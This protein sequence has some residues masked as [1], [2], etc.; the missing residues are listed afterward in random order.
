MIHSIADSIKTKIVKAI[1]DGLDEAQNVYSTGSMRIRNSIHFYKM[2]AIAN[3]VI[4]CLEDEDDIKILQ[5]ERGSYIVPLMYYI[6][7]GTVLSLMSC[8]RYSTLMNR[9]DYSRVHYF[10]ALVNFN[11]KLEIDRNQLVLDEVIFDAD[12]YEID[13]IKNQISNQLDGK[14][15]SKYITISMV[16]KGL[17]LIGVEAILTS[18]Y[19]EE[20][21]RAD[22]SQFI[23]LDYSD[24]EYYDDVVSNED[25]DLGITI[26][27]NVVRKDD[28]NEEDIKPKIGSKEN[29]A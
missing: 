23:E 17:Q 6:P 18:E 9:K 28:I 11:D 19:F 1:N 21:E 2:D 26:K 20:V 3:A 25:D 12:V 16:M 24:I 8:G 13:E 4:M 15:P 14:E 27:P 10:D 22:W 5:I 29:Q 7:D